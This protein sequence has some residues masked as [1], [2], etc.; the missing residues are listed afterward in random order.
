[1]RSRLRCTRYRSAATTTAAIAMPA[2]TRRQAKRDSSCASAVS[3][4]ARVI[5]SPVASVLASRATIDHRHRERLVSAG[6]G[7]SLHFTAACV[8]RAITGSVSRTLERPGSWG[9]RTPE[10]GRRGVPR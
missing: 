8:S 9:G 1:M 10:V 4:C 7:Q 2:V 5:S 6:V 3:K